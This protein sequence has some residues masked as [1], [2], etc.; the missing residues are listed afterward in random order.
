MDDLYAILEVVPRYSLEWFMVK[1]DI[2]KLERGHCN[3]D[4]HTPSQST[5]VNNNSDSEN[6]LEE[7][8]RK[9]ISQ[10]EQVQQEEER[11]SDHS[12]HTS[13]AKKSQAAANSTPQPKESNMSVEEQMRY[14]TEQ[15]NRVPKYSLDWFH[16][17]QTIEALKRETPK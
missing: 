16:N 5:R 7:K 17:K 8:A 4:S 11:L 3:T 10:D 12:Q 9:T 1:K 6:D 13:S 15:L 14:L 2:T